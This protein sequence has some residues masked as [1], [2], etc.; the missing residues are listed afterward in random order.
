[1]VVKETVTQYSYCR[2]AINGSRDHN[3][4]K[5]LEKVGIMFAFL[6]VLPAAEVALIAA[7]MVLW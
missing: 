6:D 5:G 7:K 1:M 2:Y 4:E 3:V